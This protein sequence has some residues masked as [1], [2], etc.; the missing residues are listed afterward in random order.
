[1]SN[2]KH[3]TREIYK[4][5]NQ[6]YKKAPYVSDVEIDINKINNEFYKSKIF[7]KVPGKKVLTSVKV[8]ESFYTSLYKAHKAIEKQLQKLF[9]KRKSR[10]SIRKIG[11]E[12]A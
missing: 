7:I 8:D 6:I 11:L 9:F 4:V 10:Q 5:K 2:Q 12:V 3:R 1:M